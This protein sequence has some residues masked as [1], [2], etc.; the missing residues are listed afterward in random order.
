M[1]FDFDEA[2]RLY[3]EDPPAFE[4]YREQVILGYLQSLPPERARQ[5]E[6]LQAEID[7]SRAARSPVEH[8]AWLGTELTKKLDQLTGK[9]I[10][11]NNALN[12]DRLIIRGFVCKRPPPA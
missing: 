5:L 2:A 7:Q 10:G 9:F 4:R 12:P 11:L 6:A 3:V 1:K 8:L